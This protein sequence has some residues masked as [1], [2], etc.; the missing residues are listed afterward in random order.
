MKRTAVYMERWHIS[1]GCWVCQ[2]C[3]RINFQQSR[4]CQAQ[5]SPGFNHH[6]RGQQ[7]HESNLRKIKFNSENGLPI[8]AHFARLVSL[9]CEDEVTRSYG[10]EGIAL[11]L[12]I[13]PSRISGAQPFLEE[14]LQPVMTYKA[15]LQG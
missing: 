14:G 4:E 2:I 13:D 12:T 11:A 15:D 8:A 7:Q 10:D 1:N 9:T 6:V 3:L 5:R